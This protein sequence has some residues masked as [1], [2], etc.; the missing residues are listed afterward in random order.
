MGIGLTDSSS[1]HT[2]GVGGFSPAVLAGC[3]ASFDGDGVTF[4][5]SQEQIVLDSVLSRVEVVVAAAR[6]VK[7]RVGAAL[8]DLSLLHNQDLV[9]P[10]NGR[11]PVGDDER[12]ASLHK[13][14]KTLLDHLLRFRVEAGS[15]FIEN[16]NSRLSQN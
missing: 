5:R 1:Q 3:A 6:G 9:G 15:G 2:Q 8:H 7:L 10:A 16:Q 11:E 14:R 13:I 4:P 12:S